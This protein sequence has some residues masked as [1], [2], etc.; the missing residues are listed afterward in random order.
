MVYM[1]AVYALNEEKTKVERFLGYIPA[2]Y[3]SDFIDPNK[4]SV[5]SFRVLTGKPEIGRVYG[6][7][8][9]VNTRHL[10]VK[11]EILFGYMGVD[12]PPEPMLD[13]GADDLVY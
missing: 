5:A 7:A 6:R 8:F 4:W 3:L 10:V 2:S 12:G 1:Y 11:D 13:H 9:F